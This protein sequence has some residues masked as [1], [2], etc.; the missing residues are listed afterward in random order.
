MASVKWIRGMLRQALPMDVAVGRK[1]LLGRDGA[2]HNENCVEDIDGTLVRDMVPCRGE[3]G[4]AVWDDDM[5]A[6][7][8]DQVFVVEEGCSSEGHDGQSRVKKV[9]PGRQKEWWVFNSMLFVTESEAISW[10]DRVLA[11][12]KA[13]SQM[14]VT[15]VPLL[16]GVP[17]ESR[18][19]VGVAL[20]KYPDVQVLRSRPGT[21]TSGKWKLDA[22]GR[23]SCGLAVD[24]L[25][26]M[27]DGGFQKQ[28]WGSRRRGS[29]VWVLG[30]SCSDQVVVGMGILCLNSLPPR[31]LSAPP[32]LWSAH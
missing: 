18:M 22:K 13:A 4:W 15:P 3:L 17:E 32:R 10:R 26:L 31:S 28:P 20:Q 23:T 21:R 14:E 30:P 27:F 16:D 2:A 6:W 19:V 5:G 11:G 25:V 29:P 1:G 7:V 12:E 8:V 9:W 24:H